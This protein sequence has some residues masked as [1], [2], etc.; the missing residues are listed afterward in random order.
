M[1]IQE[2]AEVLSKEIHL[3][4]YPHQYGRWIA[5]FPNCEI[6]EGNA[7]IG[8]YGD[9]KNPNDAIMNYAKKIRGKTLVFNAMTDKRMEF[10]VPETLQ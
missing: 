8:E 4:R 1:T 6:K 7:L 3:K 2:L 5:Y 9:A 10:T